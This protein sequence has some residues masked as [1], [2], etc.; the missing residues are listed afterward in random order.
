MSTSDA[1]EDEQMAAPRHSPPAGTPLILQVSPL[2]PTSGDQ[3]EFYYDPFAD[4]ELG[5]LPLPVHFSCLMGMSSSFTTARIHK[6]FRI[7][8]HKLPLSTSRLYLPVF[9]LKD[10]RFSTHNMRLTVNKLSTLL[11]SLPLVP[12]SLGMWQQA[13]VAAVTAA[14]LHLP[15]PPVRHAL[16][17]PSFSFRLPRSGS[18]VSFCSRT[19][20]VIYGSGP[21]SPVSLPPP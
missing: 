1:P 11:P 3:D 17:S 10:T 14:P 8:F 18:T 2:D 7:Y 9:W 4:L 13:L 16:W 12:S 19:E 5:D 15:L 6:P 21:T 20:G